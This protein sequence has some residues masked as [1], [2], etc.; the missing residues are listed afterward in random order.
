MVDTISIEIVVSVFGVVVQ[1]K[2]EDDTVDSVEAN[3]VVPS[4]LSSY[5]NDWVENRSCGEEVSKLFDVVVLG[6]VVS[7]ISLIVDS[8]DDNDVDGIVEC[9]CEL[10]VWSEFQCVLSCSLIV[11]QIDV[12]DEIVVAVVVVVVV[13]VVAKINKIHHM[14]LLEY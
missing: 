6:T 14:N 12:V 3:V 1:S 5:D 11:P 4:V 10:V 7:A 8:I 9:E 13:V 2:Y